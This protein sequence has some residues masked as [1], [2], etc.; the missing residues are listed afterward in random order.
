MDG[1]IETL[2]ISQFGARYGTGEYEF[3]FEFEHKEENGNECMAQCA[4]YEELHISLSPNVIALRHDNGYLAFHC[5]QTVSV[6]SGMGLSRDT[7]L[8]TC[9]YRGKTETYTVSIRKKPI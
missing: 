3:E 4:K 7:A 8:I 9:N 6:R 1:I 5:V 2:S